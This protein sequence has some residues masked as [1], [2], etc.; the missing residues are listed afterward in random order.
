MRGTDRLRRPVAADP[1]A[2][3]DLREAIRAVLLAHTTGAPLDPAAV[4]RLRELA[5][6]APLR[7]QIADDGSAAPAA[8]GENAVA[9]VLAA[10]VS[11]GRT[12]TW[13]RLKVC[14]NPDCRW[15]F[16]DTSRNHSSTWCDM[17]ICGSRAKMRA[18]RRR[19]AGHLTPEDDTADGA[20]AP[21]SAP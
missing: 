19:D 4:D 21:A 1:Q 14:A 5:A 6:A 17:S 3:R 10:M 13:R 7:A 11:A 12:G 18:Y 9:Q 20:C 15:A 16:Y 8:L 2:L